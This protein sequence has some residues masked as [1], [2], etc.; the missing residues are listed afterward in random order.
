MGEV[1]QSEKNDGSEPYASAPAAAVSKVFISYGSQDG[2]V[3]EKMCAALEAAGLPCWIAPRDVRAGQSYAAAI[4]EAINSCRMLVLLLSQG[5][6]D[7]PH[8]LREVE[9]ASSKRRPVLSVRMDATKLPLDLEYFLSANQW[10]DA[11]SRPIEQILPALVESVRNHDIGESSRELLGAS[12]AA[13][14]SALGPVPSPA[15]SKPSSRW[16]TRAMAITLAIA[17]VGLGYVLTNKLWLSKHIA[18]EQTKT[19]ATNV[20]SDKS[21]AV[22]PFVDLSEKHDQEYFADGM[23]EEILDIVAKIPRL[24][25]I[26]RTSSFQFKGR[27]EDLRTIGGKLGAAYVVEGSVRKAGTRIRVTAQLIDTRSG[28]HLW[29]QS[30]NKAYGDVLML[31][32]EIATAIARALQLTVVARDA[33]PLRDEHATEAYTIYLR[34]RLALDKFGAS[35]LLEAQSAFQQALQLDPALLPAAEGLAL[36]YLYRGLNENDISGREAWE[37]A[38]SAA[39]KALQISANSSS[40][41]GVLGYVAGMQDFDWT[42]AEK[43]FRTALALNPN[44]VDTLTNAA[45]LA[46]MHGD[47][48]QAM[49]RIDTSLVLDPLNPGTHQVRGMIL[50]MTHDY[51]GAESA[52]QKSIAIN[53]EIDGSRLTLAYIQLVHGRWEAALKEFTADP[54]SSSKD[55]GLALVNHALGKKQESDAALARV[56]EEVGSIWAY[57]IGCIHAYRGER[58]QAFEWLEKSRAARDG[59][60]FFVR[61]EPLLASL[62]DDPRWAALMKSMNLPN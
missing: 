44:D 6:I 55:I 21:I 8:V 22:L 51:S 41:H 58:D 19:A 38:R 47:I 10:L 28:T 29:S 31:Q 60:L 59:D 4:V 48:D 5:A 1:D 46:A 24:T 62:H 54:E 23:A 49:R 18:S 50:Y 53:P 52:L 45:Q 61:G 32:D 30:Y 15:P 27:T 37:Q 35:S 14:R 20:V 13:A 57:G 12:S 39:R 26:G 11:S 56:V 40:A 17:A 43:E 16:G 42:T 33:R 9:R 3:A 36:T 2:A 25:V 34:G 7:S